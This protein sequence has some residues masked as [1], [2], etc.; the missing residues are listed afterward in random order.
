M[1]Q[2]KKNILPLLLISILA[3]TL[4]G[5][6][7]AEPTGAGTVPLKTIAWEKGE[8]SK[9]KEAKDKAMETEPAG[10]EGMEALEEFGEYLAELIRTGRGRE[11]DACKIS[12][13]L[14]FEE[15]AA[16]AEMSPLFMHFEPY[17]QAR[18]SNSEGAV[19]AEADIN[20]DGLCDIVEY[21]HDT[22]WLTDGCGSLTLYTQDREG[23]FSV[24]CYCPVADIEINPYFC[25]PPDE[26]RL[27]AFE[28]SLYLTIQHNQY[29]QLSEGEREWYQ[30]VVYRL[31]GGKLA[32][33]LLL[34]WTMEGMKLHVDDGG[35][36]GLADYRERTVDIGMFGTGLFTPKPILPGFARGVEEELEQGDGQR[37]ELER[38]AGR[39][40]EE[41]ERLYGGKR[42]YQGHFYGNPPYAEMPDAVFRCDLDND[43][44]MEV[45]G[46]ETK[47]LG[48]GIG[49]GG[50]FYPVKAGD[51]YGKHEGRSGLQYF[52]EKD[53]ELTDFR[54]LC[55]LDIWASDYTPRM[56]WVREEGGKNITYISYLDM[57]NG[58][59]GLL[60][61]YCIEGGSYER[62][63]SA[64]CMPGD[65]SLRY[66]EAPGTFP[67]A[68]K[69]YE[70]SG[71][72]HIRIIGMEDQALE[73]VLNERIDT[74]LGDDIDGF[75]GGT[76]EQNPTRSGRILM[77]AYYMDADRLLLACLVFY[78][79]DEGWG[80]VKHDLYLD[81]DLSG[82][83]VRLYKNN[84]TMSTALYLWIADEARDKFWRA[85]A[86]DGEALEELGEYVVRAVKENGDYRMLARVI[87]E[88]LTRS[89]AAALAD[90]SPQFAHLA[91][92]SRPDGPVMG[93]VRVLEA[94]INGDG[95]SDILEYRLWEQEGCGKCGSSLAVYI[96]EPGGTYR[97]ERYPVFETPWDE[98]YN[99]LNGRADI[100]RFHDRIYLMAG[101]YIE[102]GDFEKDNKRTVVWLY[103][104]GQ[105]KVQD[106]LFLDVGASETI[107]VL[108]R[109]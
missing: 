80:C 17:G 12:R 90:I 96:Q 58:F 60:E 26:L 52:M 89:E 75:F 16:M 39:Q 10:S 54:E 62:V 21:Q 86:P 59:T 88:T 15:T 4:T 72:D 102:D 103:R 50:A 47:R 81:V 87:S 70:G 101:Q 85:S 53:G 94:D 25:V 69:V 23:N 30:M 100:L 99:L 104:F 49:V 97:E 20:G 77:N 79:R 22:G 19:I 9:W 3:I 107:S 108:E 82:G 13:I 37:E 92:Y 46:K 83:N 8:I 5:G 71:R 27:F 43:G 31:S 57:E 61:G 18:I 33:K 106:R 51:R 38:L 63:F 14:T 36:D 67:F 44:Y 74:L 28:G 6:C 32:E 105:G 2:N 78:T 64:R 48:L 29:K 68:V 41:Y 45:Y 56:F 42:V 34:D 91:Q 1:N 35:G 76:S 65:V 55:G 93:G 98:E 11:L 24:S 109:F 84:R 95:L 73:A 40:C 66:E 7:G